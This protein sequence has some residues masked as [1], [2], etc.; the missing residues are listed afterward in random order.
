MIAWKFLLKK[1]GFPSCIF[2]KHLEKKK[3]TAQGYFPVSAFIQF[4][5]VWKNKDDEKEMFIVLPCT[6]LRKN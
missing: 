2:P 5:V 6:K 1:N 3:R 4:I